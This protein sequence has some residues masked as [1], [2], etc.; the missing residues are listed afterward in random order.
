M[1]VRKRSKVLDLLGSTLCA[2]CNMMSIQRKILEHLLFPVNVRVD[3]RI[4]GRLG[5]LELVDDP[6]GNIVV[7]GR[8]IHNDFTLDCLVLDHHGLIRIQLLR[9]L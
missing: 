5:L 8:L 7:P 9:L 2:R 3:H 4:F 1:Q 6:L